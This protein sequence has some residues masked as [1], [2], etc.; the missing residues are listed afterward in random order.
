V[1]P[2][3]RVIPPRPGVHGDVPTVLQLTHHPRSVVWGAYAGTALP[4]TLLPE[5]HAE[6]NY[7]ATGS[8]AVR[9]SQV[10]RVETNLMDP[11]EKKVP[12]D[13]YAPM[14]CERR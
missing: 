7:A 1:V 14:R 2:A 5:R 3:D 12:Q 13:G 11:V 10:V 4:H 6:F 9:P 8:A